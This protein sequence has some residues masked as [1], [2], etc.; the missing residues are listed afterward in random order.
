LLAACTLLVAAPATA[1]TVVSVGAAAGRSGVL[2]RADI[3]V[4]LPWRY[5]GRF[6]AFDWAARFDADVAY[7]H[8]RSE[9]DQ[10][11]HLL[12]F[13]IIPT[14]RLSPSRAL[15]ARPYVELGL[16]AHYL[17]EH[18]LG[19]R[20]LGSSI[21]FSESVTLGVEFGRR[22]EF[23]LALMAMHESNAGLSSHNAGLTVWGVRFA[24]ALP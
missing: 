1:Q 23:G 5:G 3:A 18:D 4:S 14:I 11:S 21:Q 12:D 10:T 7:W 8:A 22:K 13:A 15:A 19:A 9:S 2:K 20:Q 6:G 16:G 24:Y 17:T